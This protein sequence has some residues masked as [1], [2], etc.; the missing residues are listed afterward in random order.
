MFKYTK[1]IAMALVSVLFV[2]LSPLSQAGA[3]NNAGLFTTPLPANDDGSTGLVNIGF[4][5]NFYGASY[6]QLY[7]NNN[8]NVVLS[9]ATMSLA[10]IGLMSGT[11]QASRVPLIVFN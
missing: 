4:N 8:G 6:S 9:M 7:V 3:I 1:K 5:L 2:A 10:L 11:L